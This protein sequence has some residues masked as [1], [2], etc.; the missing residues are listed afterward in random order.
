MEFDILLPISVF[1]IVAIS[2]IL[3]RKVIVKFNTIFE[4]K[5]LNVRD[6]LLMVISMGVMVTAIA[7]IPGQ[8]I[9]ILFISSYSYI[10]FSFF[11]I[12]TKKIY[13]A[14]G[15]TVSFIVFY[16]LYWWNKFTL[17]WMNVFLFN[18][19]V[20]LITLIITVQLGS[21]FSWKTTWIF[22]ILLTAMDIFQVS[23]TGFM[24]HSAT[25][26]IDLKLPVALILPTFPARTVIGLG[27]GDIFLSGLLSIHTS[28]KYGKRAGI[29]TAIAISTAFFFFEVTLFNLAL[30]KFFP[31]TVVVILGWFLSVGIIKFSSRKYAINT[32][33]E[34]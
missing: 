1:I 23:V 7:F 33:L 10:I 2:V 31:A 21:L 8:I 5:K 9:Q 25:K 11:Y 29:L 15:P 4:E 6:V 17:P 34:T 28:L 30:F 32:K 18:F 19:F 26:M 14:I 13:L 22:A 20:A 27:I 12:I 16:L 3:Y 24:V